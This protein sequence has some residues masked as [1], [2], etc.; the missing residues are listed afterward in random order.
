[1]GISFGPMR[2]SG[3][4]SV[5]D[6]PPNYIEDVFSTYLY[7][8]NNTARS[9]T[10]G[11][12]LAGKGGMVWIKNRTGYFPTV[13]FT[14]N[15][16]P[17][18]RL[19]LPTT[20]AQLFT[21]ETLT[22]FNSD[23]FSLGTDTSLAYVNYAGYSYCSWTFRK[24]P[25]FFDVV[26]YTGD[27]NSVRSVAHSLNCA[28][29]MVIVKPITSSGYNDNWNVC[30]RAVDVP[31]Y[32]SGVVY[33]GSSDGSGSPFGLNT[34]NASSA[35]TVT[36]PWSTT[37]FGVGNSNSKLGG[38]YGVNQ[39]GVQYVAYLFASDAGGF[40][41]TGTD[42]VITCG[43]FNT[44]SNGY[45]NIT[46]GYE[47]AW[48][49]YKVTDTTG[50]WGMGD[51]MRGMPANTLTAGTGG[52]T[53]RLFANTSAAETTETNYVCNVTSTGFAFHSGGYPSNTFIYIAIRRGPMKTPTDATTVF[54]PITTSTDP[55]NLSVGFPTDWYIPNRRG[56]DA[57]RYAQSRLQ[58]ADQ[59]LIITSTGQEATY[60]GS[61]FDLQNNFTS[62][63]FFGTTPLVNYFFKRAPGFFDEVCF[64]GT[65]PTSTQNVNHNL[66]VIPELIIVK[67]RDS[68]SS[69]F[70]STFNTGTLNKSMIL[71][72]DI[73]SPAGA[74]AFDSATS[75]Y[76]VASNAVGG[77]GNPNGTMVAYLFAT[78]PGVSKVGTYTGNGTTQTINCGF[79]SGARFLLIKRTDSTGDWYVWDSARGMTSGNDPYLLL[80]ST[81]AEVTNTN[82]VDT[83]TTG[84]KV[85]AAAPAAINASG[86]T[87][88][89][90]AIA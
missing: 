61:K 60:A 53:Q 34:T 84:F 3:F 78:C 62:A 77:V 74:I 70:V 46:L 39:S 23:G 35:Y 66:G 2:I 82:Y 20:Q 72:S 47:P 5:I 16:T 17:N 79:A 15:Q 68:S 64:K 22:A 67:Q 87:Y 41:L 36:A 8:G 40:G 49:M 44:D 1:M 28:P 10:N 56:G 73:A 59:Y 33:L 69:W 52:N 12:D 32:P 9:I 26:T 43:S 19:N 30:C 54:S 55:S 21:A 80:N 50:G 51:V 14:T 38:T 89:F 24:Q 90:L 75:T 37:T 81:A 42:N 4:T 58:G 88:I 13:S 25:K 31:G 48:V 29:G 45:A 65:Y 63:A 86:G 71:N 85:T 27:G 83:D 76:F 18:Y 11:I 7:D 57:P 6:S